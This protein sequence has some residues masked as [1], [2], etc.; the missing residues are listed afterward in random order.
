[1]SLYEII[2]IVLAFLGLIA[3]ILKVWSKTQ[4]DIAM[5]QIQ[6]KNSDEKHA[7]RKKELEDHKAENERQLEKL[8]NENREDHRLMFSKLDEI[9]RNFN[10]I[11]CRE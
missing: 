5:L 9:N 6:I 3:L 7:D 4:T 2:S 1:M 8:H 11:N 10:R